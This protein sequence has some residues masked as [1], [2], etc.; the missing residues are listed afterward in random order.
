MKTLS[1]KLS[2][3]VL[4]SVLVTSAITGALVVSNELST[5]R[6]QIAQDGQSLA[7]TVAAMSVE[8]MVG[9]PDIPYIQ[10]HLQ[11]TV[12]K[13]DRVQRIRVF[14]RD[15]SLIAEH[16]SRDSETITGGE[17]HQF[18]APVT[19]GLDDE[20]EVVGRVQVTFDD[21]LL[22]KL[23]T[24]SIWTLVAGTTISSAILALILFLSLRRFVLEPVSKLNRQVTRIASGDLQ[25][26]IELSGDDELC[27]FGRTLDEMRVNLHKSKARIEQQV[28]ELRQLDLMKDEFLANTSHELKTPLNGIIGLSESLLTGAYGELDAKQQDAL[29]KVSACADRLWKMTASILK[30]SRLRGQEKTEESQAARHALGYHLEEALIDLYATAEQLGIPLHLKFPE[31]EQFVYRR[32]DVEQIIRILVD[33][34]LKFTKV[35]EVSVLAQRWSH[36]KG[37]G[38][39]IA[40]RD[41]GPGI[42]EATLET[43]FKPFVQGFQHETRVHGGVGLGLSIANKLAELIEARIMVESELGIG[44]TFTLLIPE[45]KPKC[46]LESLYERWPPNP[47]ADPAVTTSEKPDAEKDSSPL[48]LVAAESDTSDP[49]FRKPVAAGAGESRLA[50]ILVVDDEAVNREV[51]SQS[52]RGRYEV[53]EAS[54]GEEGLAVLRAGDVDVVLL[55]IMMPKVSGYDVLQIMAKEGMLEEIPVIVLSAK[56]SPDAIV[57]GLEHGAVD[58]VGKPFHRHELLCRVENHLQIKHQRDRL[59]TEVV[60]KAQALELAEEASRVKSQFLANMSHELRTPLNGILGFVEIAL[61]NC[62]EDDS[63]QTQALETIRSCAAS[64]VESVGNVLD[65]DQIEQHEPLD[66][67]PWELAKLV[68]PILE[69]WTREAKK[70]GIELEACPPEYAFPIWVDAAPFQDCLSHLLSNAVKFTKKGTITVEMGLSEPTTETESASNGECLLTVMIRDSGVGIA[71]D[72]LTAVFEPFSQ[73]DNSH[74]RCFDGMGLGLALARRRARRMGGDVTLQSELGRGTTATIECVVF[75]EEPSP[76]TKSPS[77]QNAQVSERGHAVLAAQ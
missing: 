70:A 57:K 47:G 4:G 63:E 69:R 66:Y 23:I 53:V 12:A 20:E 72:R 3:T 25:T 17:L 43:I 38:F 11:V 76:G 73:A 49:P 56:S 34:A 10:T 14:D 15:D 41:T 5:L 60:A 1:S 45:E 9:E 13:N 22:S 58:Y 64:L 51:V 65:L 62:A 30:F 52:L 39:Q 77:D 71:P 61:D 18:S 32:N 31:D 40:V 29:R 2:V 55:D 74:S 44:T 48:T 8:Q 7:D 24:T 36:G 54:G 37:A 75:T 46:D 16:P 68:E 21:T 42:D 26:E 35:G 67:S 27:H 33:N 59:R 50:R 28:E 19:V 6:H